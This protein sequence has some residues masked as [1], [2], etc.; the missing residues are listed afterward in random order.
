MVRSMKSKLLPGCLFAPLAILLVACGGDWSEYQPNTGTLPEDNVQVATYPTGP[1]GTNVGDII[2]DLAYNESF[3]DPDTLCKPAQKYDLTKA[4][5]VNSL[6]L[7]DIFKGNAYC[8][9]RK[10][11]FL[12]LISSAGW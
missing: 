12:W 7:S 10:K 2:D 3:Y 11:Q 5:G 9:S 8:P 4:G 1:Y 6:S